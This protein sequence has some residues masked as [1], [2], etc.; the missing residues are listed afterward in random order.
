MFVDTVIVL[1]AA[2]AAV[3]VV[4]FAAA[5]VDREVRPPERTSSV[6]ENSIEQWKR[7]LLDQ[8]QGA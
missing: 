1:A 6:P 2:A 8:A 3:D 7:L 4:V 5:L